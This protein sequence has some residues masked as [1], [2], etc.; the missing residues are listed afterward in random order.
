[1][2]TKARPKQPTRN[3]ELAAAIAK[4]GAPIYVIA[5]RAEVH[6]RAL[7]DLL[8]RRRTVRPEVE[9]RIA[10]TLGVERE[11]LFGA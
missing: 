11:V 8:A 4:T 6:P 10:A 2:P 5:A 3:V 9:A 1:M 7:G